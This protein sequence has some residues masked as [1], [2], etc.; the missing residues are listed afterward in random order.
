MATFNSFSPIFGD[1]VGKEAY[2]T[3][4]DGK[5]DIKHTCKLSKASLRSSLGRF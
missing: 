3:V 2:L 5:P 4:Q 1:Q